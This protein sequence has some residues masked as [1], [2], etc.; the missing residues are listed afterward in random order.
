MIFGSPTFVG[1][2]SFE[3]SANLEIQRTGTPAN[4]REEFFE[5]STD[6]A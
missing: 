1:E 6:R 5:E 2:E 4:R 3:D